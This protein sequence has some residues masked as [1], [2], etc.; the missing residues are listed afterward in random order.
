MHRGAH[1][2]QVVRIISD[3]DVWVLNIGGKV[4]AYL[5]GLVSQDDDDG[6]CLGGER[7][8]YDMNQYRTTGQRQQQFM[9]SSTHPTGTA[10]C[11]YNNTGCP[12]CMTPICPKTTKA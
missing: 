6:T 7:S 11:H 4:C 12:R 9:S 8:V 1:A 5:F 3:D 10:R 2:L